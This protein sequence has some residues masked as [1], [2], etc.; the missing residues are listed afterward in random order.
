MIYK[1]QAMKNEIIRS[2]KSIYRFSE[3]KDNAGSIISGAS[4]SEANS[5]TSETRTDSDSPL[6]QYLKAEMQFFVSI[7]I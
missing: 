6:L 5:L 1:V 2:V 4:D 3:I 7:I